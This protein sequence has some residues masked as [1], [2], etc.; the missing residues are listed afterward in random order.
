MGYQEFNAD[1]MMLNCIYL[2][3]KASLNMTCVN[4]CK[5]TKASRVISANGVTEG[6]ACTVYSPRNSL[7]IDSLIVANCD[8]FVD[9][10]IDN[11]IDAMAPQD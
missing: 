7:T 6:A 10:K 2:P 9:M 3:R 11:F 4:A 1:H 8:Q 5:F